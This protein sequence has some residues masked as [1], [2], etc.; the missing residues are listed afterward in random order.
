MK[1]LWICVT[2]LFLLWQGIPTVKAQEAFV[3]DD[4]HI[5]M[6]VEEDGTYFV[7]E[8]FTLDF[9]A[10]RHGFYRTIPVRYEMKWMDEESGKVSQKRYYFPIDH[11]ACGDTICSIDVD[12]D[13][14]MIKLGDP[15]KKIIG[16]QHYTITYRV[17]TK[18]LDMDGKQMLYWNLIG[19][20]FDTTIKK[21]SYTI[22]MP[23]SFDKTKI[24]AYSG[25]Y[26]ETSDDLSFQ[27]DGNII[28]GELKKPLSNY[29]S[30]TIKLDLENDY[31]T[32]PTPT[33]YMFYMALISGVITFISLLL[34][35]RF[36][37]DDDVIVTVEFQ[38]PDGLDSAA[39][40]YIVDGCADSKDILSLIIDWANR[41]FLHIHEE[42]GKHIKLEK[43]KDMD[44]TNAKPYELTFFNAIFKDKNIVEEDDLKESHVTNG[45]VTAQ[46]KLDKYFHAKT[47]R[48]FTSSSIMLQVIMT[49][50]S[51]IP[52]TIV[53][54]AAYMHYE[55]IEF[56]I[57]FIFYAIGPLVVILVSYIVFRKRHVISKAKLMFAYIA[58]AIL[59][60]IVYICGA[61]IIVIWGGKHAWLYALLFMV[62]EVLLFFVTIF[63]DKRTPQA[64]RWLGQILGLREFIM[65]CEKER[66]ELLVNDQ[67]DAFFQILP[68]AYVLGVSDVWAKKFESVITTQPQWYHSTYHGNTF[69]TWLW[70][71][72]FH[73]AFSNT[74]R[75]LHYVEPS[76]SG[77]GFGGGSFGGGSFGGGFSGGGFGGG[78]GGSW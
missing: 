25:S 36:G 78:G 44:S 57:P 70:W 65:T 49:I 35:W 18:D 61:M 39:V 67:P 76:K 10:R 50:L 1:K 16:E 24:S 53:V 17:H 68:Y 71:S 58:F 22:E 69:S 30:A 62:M 4:L 72:S 40:G 21:M 46:K 73:H 20:G 75:A 55:M 54:A 51:L 63:M 28:K 2:M 15:D 29:E 32:F 60:T 3:I 37:K 31:F 74:N 26:K 45:F 34:F 66:L 41:G 42:E 9:R 59:N 43:I 77:T 8:E 33:N 27:V 7:K 64:N 5:H 6:R 19:N 47:R 56:C 23:K 12:S 38:A 11:I 14:A 13:G 48:V 52:C